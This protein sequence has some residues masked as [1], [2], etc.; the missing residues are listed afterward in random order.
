[1]AYRLQEAEPLPEGVKRIA[2][3]ELD[4][5]LAHLRGEAGADDDERV[6][7]ARKA[8]K[9]TRALLRLVRDEIGSK[10]RRQENDVLRDAAR[11]LSEVRDADVLVATATSLRD[12]TRSEPTKAEVGRVV[13]ALT[14]RREAVRARVVEEEDVTGGVVADIEAARG[15]IDAWPVERP[16]PEVFLGGL[17]RTA[18]RGARRMAAAYEAAAEE[19]DEAFHEWRKRAKDLWYHA[20]VLEPAAP[21]AI[22][23]LVAL[24]DELGD[25]LGLDHDLAVLASTL[26]ELEPIREAEALREAMHALIERRRFDLQRRALPLGRRVH[27]E[28]GKA[29]ARRLAAQYEAWRLEERVASRRWLTPADAARV[30]SLLAS[31]E[32]GGSAARRRL[33]EGLRERGLKVS[34]LPVTRG[35][36][37]DLEDF[38][39]LVARGLVC[40]GE[41]SDLARAAP[42]ADPLREL[43]VEIDPN[44]AS[45]MSP[46]TAPA[47]LAAHGWDQA[48]WVILDDVPVDA[49]IVA[50]GHRAD[51]GHP[52]QGWEARR[53]ATRPEGSEGPTDDG[54][55]CLRHDGWVYLIGS[56]YGSKEGPL[57]LERQFI[58]RFREDDLTGPVDAADTSLEIAH[59]GFR[60]HRAVNDALVDAGLE[61]FDL[62][63]PAREATVGAAIAAGQRDEAS[64]AGLVR[65]EDLPINIEGAAARPDG[66][67]LLGLRFPVTAAGEPIVVEIAGLRELFGDDSP[68][69][70]VR[71]VWVLGGIGHPPA[72]A[73]VR[74]MAERPEGGFHV[75]T[76][77]L[78]STGKGSILVEEHPEAGRAR[79]AHFL[80]DLPARRGGGRVEARMLREFPGL[81]RVEGVGSDHLGRLFYVT[82]E[83][84]RV[85]LRYAEVDAARASG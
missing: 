59:T 61:L 29:L 57:E 80:V 2:R 84:E 44:E 15:R 20:R 55:D 37:F 48:F 38:E 70:E 41:A 35:R 74:G 4:G 58:G 36:S 67:V 52:E 11:R 6:H 21:G 8:L 40:I 24:T 33:R 22:G 32:D 75:L 9:K 82:D 66:T 30:R 78:D 34:E 77:N 16:G 31:A 47:V 54:E 25:L 72:P 43:E 51:A 23:D 28:G 53:L 85:H 12:H 69:P 49:G 81:R 62:S 79:S 83:D 46:L 19:R 63:G 26:D 50:V 14:E 73:G 64:W 17:R 13:R 18:E 27:A 56:H 1:V 45:G 76:G 65:P 5:A 71:G 42:A 39:S 60:L 68:T 10:V 3:A 7:E